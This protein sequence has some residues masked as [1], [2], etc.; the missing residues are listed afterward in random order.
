M[1]TRTLTLELPDEVLALLGSPEAA[2]AKAKEMLVLELLREASISQ[3]RAAELLGLS[4]WQ[5]IDLMA[6]RQIPSGPRTPEEVREE[7]A[8][9]RRYVQERSGRGGD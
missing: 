2:P 1:G 9:I 4:R 3:G 8:S 5:I 7:F 6:E